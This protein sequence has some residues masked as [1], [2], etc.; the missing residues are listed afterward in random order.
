MLNPVSNGRPVENW[1]NAHHLLLQQYMEK[2]LKV[3]SFFI[4]HKNSYN[5]NTLFKKKNNGN[6]LKYIPEK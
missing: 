1:L 4:I 3:V 5:Y 2:L 6:E